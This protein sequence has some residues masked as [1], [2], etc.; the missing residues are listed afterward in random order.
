MA[1]S[2]DTGL[3]NKFADLLPVLINKLLFF[4]VSLSMVRLSC[5]FVYAPSV[6]VSVKRTYVLSLQ[7][8]EKFAGYGIP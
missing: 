7:K 5:L 4:P 2:R 3:D 1:K 6:W 8:V